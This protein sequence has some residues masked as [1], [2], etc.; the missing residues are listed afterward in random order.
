[1][2]NNVLSSDDLTKDARHKL[3]ALCSTAYQEDFTLLF[4]Q[5]HPAVHIM[6]WDGS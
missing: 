1:M 3:L 4:Q 2:K 5:L 6:G